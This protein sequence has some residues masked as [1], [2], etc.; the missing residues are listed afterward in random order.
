MLINILIGLFLIVL[1]VMIQGYG[2]IVWLNYVS[3]HYVLLSPEKFLKKRFQVLVFSALFL[4]ML[5]F[6]EANLW[7]F[8]YYIHPSISEF[9]T[10]EKS[11][12]FSLVTFTTL[13]YGEIT[14][15]SAHRL[16]AGFEAANGVLMLGWSTALMFTTVQYV[17]KISEEK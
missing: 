7:A 15:S 2:T 5:H 11:V 13:G 1:T 6:F 8:V 17:F 3:K 16:L 14:I 4:L 9:E 12:Y 10:F